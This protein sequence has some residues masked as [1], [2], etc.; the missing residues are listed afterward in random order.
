MTSIAHAVPLWYAY[1]TSSGVG[2][3]F[4]YEMWG[5]PEGSIAIAEYCPEAPPLSTSSACQ[6]DPSNLAYIRLLA[7][8]L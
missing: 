5:L 7:L 4:T 1:I 8:A 3:E 6:E 2:V